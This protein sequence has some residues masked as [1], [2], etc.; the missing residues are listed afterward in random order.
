M[1]HVHPGLFA[2]VTFGLAEVVAIPVQ[3]AD[4]PKAALQFETSVV[5]FNVSALT[6]ATN[7]IA[8]QTATT[9]EVSLP[10]DVLFDFDKADIR[11]DA[12]GPLHEVAQLIREKARGPVI[13]QGYTDALGT[14]AYN[15]RLSERR[16]AAVKAWLTA[17]E[18]LAASEFTTSGFGS[19]NPVAPNR[20]PDGSD[21]AASRQMNR[22]VTFVIYTSIAAANGCWGAILGAVSG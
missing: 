5:D 21:N 1:H 7:L 19:L 14:D 18:G 20:N 11:P 22:R 8:T 13:I 15:R 9:I 12:Q 6:F 10:A 17:R 4:L 16:A 3:G 2:A